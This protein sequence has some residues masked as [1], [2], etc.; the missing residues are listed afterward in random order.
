MQYPDRPELITENLMKLVELT[1]DPCVH[2]LQDAL[3]PI[4]NSSC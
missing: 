4:M 3:T 2:G 1:P